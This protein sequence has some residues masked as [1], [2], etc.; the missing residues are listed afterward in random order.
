HLNS[1]CDTLSRAQDVYLNVSLAIAPG[2]AESVICGKTPRDTLMSEHIM[3][4]LENEEPSR[5]F[6]RCELWQLL[7]GFDET[8]IPMVRIEGGYPMVEGSGLIRGGA[9][10]DTLSGSETQIYLM[11]VCRADGGYLPRVRVS[12]KLSVTLEILGCNVHG[13]IVSLVV[14]LSSCEGRLNVM[15]ARA[16]AEISHAAEHEIKNQIESLGEKIAFKENYSVH[17]TL[18]SSGA[19]RKTP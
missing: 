5:R 14:A 11:V 19:T 7:R 10:A 3:N 8:L 1:V 13:D 15:D 17:V 6:P 2:T 12:D 4:I 18:G 16:R 9:L